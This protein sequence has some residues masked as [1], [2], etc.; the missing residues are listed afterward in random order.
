MGCAESL[1]KISN[2]M[3]CLIQP[4]TKRPPPTFVGEHDDGSSTVLHEGQPVRWGPLGQS[5]TAAQPCIEGP[6][7]MLLFTAS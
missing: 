7:R 3:L 1:K 4:G 5:C 6:E 2:C